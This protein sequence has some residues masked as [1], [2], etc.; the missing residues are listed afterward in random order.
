M[1]RVTLNKKFKKY[2]GVLPPN[3][4]RLYLTERYGETKLSHCPEHRDPDKVTPAQRQA[5]QLIKQA[6]ALA[7]ADLRDPAKHDEWL[8]RRNNDHSSWNTYKTLR[9]YVIA[10]YR[11][12]LTAE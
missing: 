11:K 12:Q 3:D 4:H 8:L 1:A 7:D 10:S 2:T 9:G 5:F 6:S